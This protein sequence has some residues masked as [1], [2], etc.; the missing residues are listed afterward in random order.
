MIKENI[1]FTDEFTNKIYEIIKEKNIDGISLFPMLRKENNKLLLGTLIEINNEE[2]F[3]K[4]KVVRPK[5]WVILDENNYNLKEFNETKEKDYM[6]SNIIPLDKEYDDTFKEE[7]KKVE[8]Y[9]ID[10]K[11]KYSKYLMEDI[12][13]EIINN[14]NKILDK[15]DNT[16]IVDDKR[17][18]A[19]DYLIANIEGEINK[20][21]KELVDIVQTNRYS[22]II[23]YYQTLI[24]EILKEYKET[25]S[26]NTEKMKLA[27]TILDTYYGKAYGIK[28]FF[29]V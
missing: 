5:Y 22:T 13:T 12:K 1:K 9:S 29:N 17:V 3:N 23:Y 7:M 16:L 6:D 18:D 28:Y 11:I 24:E 4:N 27:S 19:K 21:V 15:I 10:K 14:Q 26:I 25:S 20:K 2:L 8:K